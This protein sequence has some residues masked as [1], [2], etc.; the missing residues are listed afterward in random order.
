M[1]RRLNYAKF[2]YHCCEKLFWAQ[3]P[4]HFFAQS[5]VMTTRLTIQDVTFDT[6]NRKTSFFIELVFCGC[7]YP[8]LSIL[9][10]SLRLVIGSPIA[11]VVAQLHFSFHSSIFASRLTSRKLLSGRRE[12]SGRLL[13]VAEVSCALSYWG[14]LLTWRPLTFQTFQEM[15][16]KSVQSANSSVMS[17]ER[18][19]H[20]EVA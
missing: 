6:Q 11:K 10:L 4:S 1:I 19:W 17:L 3:E 15:V 16:T 2:D 18:V 7:L 8:L 13:M 12:M 20:V 9:L 14:Q 5:K